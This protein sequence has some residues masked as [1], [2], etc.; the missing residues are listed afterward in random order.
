MSDNLETLLDR[1]AAAV[2]SA[3][4][5]VIAAGA[6][7]GVDSGLPD[8][9]GTEGFW[10]AYPP[11]RKLNLEFMDVANPQWFHDDPTLAWGFY[12][13]RLNLYRAAIPHAGFAIL[14]RWAAAKPNGAFIF[15][16][17]V[18]GQFQ[19]A[20]FAEDQI[21]ECHGSVHWMQCLNGCGGVIFSAAGATVAIDA[22]SM[23]AAEPLPRCQHCDGAARP[24]ILM[25]DDYHWDAG[26]T[27]H[28]Q[29]H[30]Q[31]WLKM[32]T[33]VPVIIEMGAGLAIP[34]VRRFCERLARAANAPLIRINV[35]ESEGPADRI[36]LPMGALAALTAI[37]AR[38]QGS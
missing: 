24:N 37:D 23:R 16:S 36:G 26:R 34:T 2:A 14:Q 22:E 35:R 10:K 19:K 27:E 32:L 8:F 29:Q 4:A 5:L 15:T 7:M 18:D 11:Y 30:L 33:T 25:F 28:Q 31:A 17:N 20:G 6:G 13:H 38:L 21:V 9:R 3:D 1:A 12:G